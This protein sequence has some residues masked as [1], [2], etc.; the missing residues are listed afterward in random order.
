MDNFS[1]LNNPMNDP[2]YVKLLEK[3]QGY[4][5]ALLRDDEKLADNPVLAGEYQGKL[6]L[7]VARLFAYLNN[8]V[9][10]QV[11][12]SEDYSK[13]RERIYKEQI[14]LGK[15]PSA[16]SSHAS[17]TTRQLANNAAI[18]KLRVDQIRNNYERYNSIAIYLATRMKEFSAER[19]MG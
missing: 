15:S 5:L 11:M 14:A 18:A 8:F 12:V 3:L 17:E 16:A 2:G 10:L 4:H 7:E 13:E 19:Y 6:R 9:D 1:T